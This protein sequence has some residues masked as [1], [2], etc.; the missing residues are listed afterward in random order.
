[1]LVEHA[2]REERT[3]LTI[4]SAEARYDPTETD[5]ALSYA[6]LQGTA[7]DMTYVYN[8]SEPL[9]NQMTIQIFND[10]MQLEL[11][12]SAWKSGRVNVE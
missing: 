4:S 1:M 3:A 12:M 10:Y 6:L 11:L 5:N 2:E 7:E 8:G 9:P